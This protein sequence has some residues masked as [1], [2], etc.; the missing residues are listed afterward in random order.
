MRLHLKLDTVGSPPTNPDDALVEGLI[1]T[2]REH[3][4]N[5]TGKI[6]AA[7]TFV[8]ALDEFPFDAIKLMTAPVTGVT[9]IQYVDTNG[10]LQTL[11]STKYTLDAYDEP[12]AVYPAEPWP[13]TK[14]VPN[15]VLITFTAGFTDTQSPNPFPMP[16][17]IKQAMLLTIGHLYENREAVIDSRSLLELPMG[18]TTLLTQSRINMGV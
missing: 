11:A 18:V 17:A 13:A 8:L 10:T 14:I 5:Y 9:S 6:L 15:A 4:E 12:C 2:A 3:A 1:S 16:K 7:G